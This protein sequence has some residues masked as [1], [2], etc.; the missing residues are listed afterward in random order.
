MEGAA[1][2]AKDAVDNAV[3][4]RVVAVPQQVVPRYPEV[5][6]CS[7]GG[8]ESKELQEAR[9]RANRVRGRGAAVGA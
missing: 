2:L 3:C 5:V 7:H 9:W 4:E 1:G 8:V 6:V